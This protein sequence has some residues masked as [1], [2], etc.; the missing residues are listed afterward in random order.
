MLVF[1]SDHY[2]SRPWCRREVIEAKRLGAHIVVVDTLENGEPRRFPYIGNVPVIR[3]RNA[4]EP[5]TEARR[6]IDRAV[7]EAL[8]LKFNHA[9]LKNFAGPGEKVLAAP[10][11]AFNLATTDGV[12]PAIYLY[13]DPPLGREELEILQ[14]L[15]PTSSFITPLTR[16][17][18]NSHLSETGQIIAVS[19]S[20]SDDIARYGLSDRLFAT[21]ADEIH[22]YLLM[23]GLK[24]AYG[25]A[26]KGDFSSGSNFTL[27][28]FDLVSSYSKLA[29]GVRAKPLVNAV[30]NIAPWP[31]YLT[32]ADDEW[33]LFAGNVA[34]YASGERPNLPWSDDEIFPG[35]DEKRNLASDNP[36]RRYA[37]PRGLSSMREQMT[38]VTN[39]RVAIGGKLHGFAGLL[40]G[41]IE[42]AWMSIHKHLPLYVVGA[43]GGAGRA[44]CDLLLGVDRPEFSDDWA[45][46]RIDDFEDSCAYYQVHGVPRISLPE[47]AASIRHASSEGID[48][49]LNNGLGIDENIEL[50]RS[51]NPQRIS[52]LILT[53]LSRL[54]T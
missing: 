18:S 16:L 30:F 21:L 50:M 6:I 11:E 34:Q 26:L 54:S 23:A 24:I 44:V 42:E 1:Q 40:P 53:G 3:W 37:W 5:E 31:L 43:Y 32:Y 12:A 9:F 39:A 13:P 17:A 22:L 19:I 27:R 28:L 29:E 49:A 48:K 15:S 46:S 45:K 35:N 8:R 33:A 36:I 38:T 2:G 25:G 10:P 47:I 41:V 14:A 4:S 7:L 20:E 51:S 52:S